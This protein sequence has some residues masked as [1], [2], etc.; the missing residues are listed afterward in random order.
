MRACVSMRGAEFRLREPETEMVVGEMLES[1]SLVSL[2]FPLEWSYCYCKKKQYGAKVRVAISPKVLQPLD[3]SFLGPRG[4][5]VLTLAD[6]PVRKKNLDHLYTQAYMPY[7]SSEDSSNQSDGTMGSPGL[8]PPL[9]PWV[10]LA[11]QMD[12]LGTLNRC[13]GLIELLR[14]PWLPCKS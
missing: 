2:Q 11:P 4:P 10:P 9:T 5:L 14:S 12:P 6:P 3:L 1:Q 8:T 7:E 13:L